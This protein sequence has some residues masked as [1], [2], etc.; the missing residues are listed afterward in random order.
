M[1]YINICPDTGRKFLVEANGDNNIAEIFDPPRF[2]DFLA[3][4]RNS[5]RVYRGSLDEKG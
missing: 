5:L 2:S 3:S 4:D 1:Y